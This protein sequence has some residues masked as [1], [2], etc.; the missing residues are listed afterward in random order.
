[1]EDEVNP[2][3]LT[4]A[5]THNFLVQEQ[6]NTELYLWKH[7]WRGMVPLGSANRTQLS[8]WPLWKKVGRLH[9]SF[10]LTH[11]GFFLHC[12]EPTH[13]ELL[14]HIPCPHDLDPGFWCPHDTGLKLV[15][16]QS[17][18]VKLLTSLFGFAPS[19]HSG[20]VIFC[21]ALL[22]FAPVQDLLVQFLVL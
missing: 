5:S 8:C 20:E 15:S 7:P 11:Q 1:M 4:I 9:E 17:N 18:K 21:S 13:T 2:W 19:L 22:Q 6:Q 12:Y 14:F 16:A 3:L 10:D